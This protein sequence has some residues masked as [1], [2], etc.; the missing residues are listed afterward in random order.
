M[1]EIARADIIIILHGA[2]DALEKQSAAAIVADNAGWSSWRQCGAVRQ[3]SREIGENGNS[4]QA[5]KDR[6][7]E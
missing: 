6:E 2:S 4:R 3:N 7:R 5:P 1:P